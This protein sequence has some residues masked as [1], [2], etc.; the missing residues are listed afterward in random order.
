MFEPYRLEAP[1][2]WKN[3]DLKDSIESCPPTRN[4]GIKLERERNFYSVKPLLWITCA[5]KWSSLVAQMIKNPPAKQEIQVQSLCQEDPLKNEMVTHSRILRWRIP[6]KEGPGGL[7]FMASQRVEHDW[8][9][10]HA[11]TITN[12]VNQTVWDS[13]SSHLFSWLSLCV[14]VKKQKTKNKKLSETRNHKQSLSTNK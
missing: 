10:K 8:A 4:I 13:L 5:N 12:L 1:S 7:H 2:A 3:L 11:C 6:W 9:T 14:N